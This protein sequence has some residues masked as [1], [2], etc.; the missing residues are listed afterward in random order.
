MPRTEVVSWN[1][2]PIVPADGIERREIVG[3]GASLKRID[4]KAGVIAGRHSHDH[5][6]FLLV[7]EGHAVLQ[8]ES[9]TIELRPGMVVRFEPEAWH[10]AEFLEDTVLVEVNLRPAR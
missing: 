4:I 5:E 8:V 9:G 10:G 3:D 6:Q 7:L 2:V 1:D